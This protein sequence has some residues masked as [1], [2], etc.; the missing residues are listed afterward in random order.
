MHVTEAP[1]DNMA[2]LSSSAGQ[3]YFSFAKCKNFDAGSIL[4]LKDFFCKWLIR[5]FWLNVFKI[6]HKL[7]TK[8]TVLF[9]ITC[10][11]SLHEFN[12]TIFKWSNVI[13]FLINMFVMK[14]W[15]ICFTLESLSCNPL[16]KMKP[17]FFLRVLDVDIYDSWLAP[18]FKSTMYTETWQ[19]GRGKTPSNCSALYKVAYVRIKWTSS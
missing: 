19:N 6:T 4:I 16:W 5:C 18:Y 1:C 12:Q 15:L 14:Y 13:R 7:Y 8:H 10:M 17:F 9:E 2:K 3:K 11:K